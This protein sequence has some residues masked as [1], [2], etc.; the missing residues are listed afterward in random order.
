[1]KEKSLLGVKLAN[2]FRIE[3]E[4]FVTCTSCTLPHVRAFVSHFA[5]DDGSHQTVPLLRTV[6]LLPMLILQ[7]N[8]FRGR[9]TQNEVG[10]RLI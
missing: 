9:F 7:E 8:A 2:A 3:L 6:P 10:K 1:M 4:D 5:G